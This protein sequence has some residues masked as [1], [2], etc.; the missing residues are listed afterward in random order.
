MATLQVEGVE[1][2]EHTCQET[3]R[4]TV[5]RLQQPSCGTGPPQTFSSHVYGCAEVQ[6]CTSESMWVNLNE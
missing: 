6:A 3:R 2:E 4:V 1:S 5:R